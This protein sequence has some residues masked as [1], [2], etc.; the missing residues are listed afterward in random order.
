[1]I[2][3]MEFTA[4]A[5]PLDEKKVKYSSKLLLSFCILILTE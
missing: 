4:Y 3:D 5:T 2:A 1:M